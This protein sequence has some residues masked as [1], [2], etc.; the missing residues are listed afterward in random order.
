M[1]PTARPSPTLLRLFAATPALIGALHAHAAEEPPAK[2]D[3]KI[4][5]VEVKGA[6]A[7]YDARRND[8]ATKIVV[9]QEEILKNGDTTIGEVL[10]RLPGVT[11]GGVQGR[12]GDIRMR[13]LGAGYTQ[14]L[15]NG[16]PAP[17]GFSMDSIS[18]DM[19]ERI[20]VMRA[21]TA[22]YSTQ[23]IAGGINIV[24][25]RAVQ[26]AQRELKVGLQD[27]NH[28]FGT[29]T[30]FQLSDKSGIMS[31]AIG[32]NVTYAHFDRPSE[33]VQEEFDLA[34][35]RV[36][37]RRADQTNQGTF[38]ALG[39]SP[40]VNFN[41][42]PGDIV[43]WQ[44]F[45]N[46]NQVRFNTTERFTQLQGDRQAQ[47][48]GTDVGVATDFIMARSDVTWT[49]KLAAGAKL[50]IKG[51]INYNN[52]DTDAPSLQYAPGMKPALQRLV[53]STQT[54]KGLTSTGKYSTPIIEH[55]ALAMGW[56]L[57]VSKR[58]EDRIQ[59][60][61]ALLP[62][63]PPQPGQNQPKG[64]EDL[65]QVFSADIK[66][67]ALYAQDEWQI[68]DRWSAYFGLRWEGI[69][70]TSEGSD[71]AAVDNKSSVFSPLFQTLWKLPDT[72]NDQVR[73]GVTRTYKAPGVNQLI[74]RRFASNN[75]SPTQPDFSG[76][77]Q[78][79]PE[80]AWGLDLAYEHYLPGGGLMTASTYMR[81][82]DNSIRNRVDLI[83]T[84]WIS[85]PVN[86]G[87][88]NTHGIELE[89]KLPLR[90][91]YAQAPAVE[92]RANVTRNWSTL[93]SVPGPNN[94]L[95]GQTPVSGTVGFDYKMDTLPVTTGASFSFQSGGPVRVSDKQF[96][97]SAPKRT[98]DWY[99]VMKFSPKTQLR[100]SVS[101]LLHQTNVAQNAFLT[102]GGLNAD[103][104]YTPTVAIVRALMEMKF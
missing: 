93:D 42:G 23:A 59:D 13:G 80:L 89:A 29:N 32:G 19:V 35:K 70:T 18:P 56:D 100:V 102:P 15:L 83:D 47:Y 58:N 27:D 60:E 44:S 88:A 28:K 7:Q 76:N 14:I 5:Q 81:R 98:L 12:G 2:K 77:P 64:P 55:H 91:L 41:L 26:S 85:H 96:S 3:E 92:V 46:A 17:P 30:N 103:T 39:L 1:K 51:G 57:G 82:I 45:V 36:Q 9:T 34:G 6:A 94:R 84:L 22:E 71:Y 68:T 25:K 4:Q 104:T 95:D 54:E 75:N 62:P 33:L 53:T 24:L 66:R 67:L 87:T 37:W 86:A 69:Q 8:T 43:T 40:R 73:L 48:V 31:Y 72:K 38:K 79:K 63:P 11:I 90:S 61:T 101:N 21:A 50:E 74:P 52:R 49:R 10:K 65:N 20:E 78:L 16:E 99:G 97:W